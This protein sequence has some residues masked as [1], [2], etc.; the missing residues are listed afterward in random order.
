M[1]TPLDITAVVL[2]NEALTG[3]RCSEERKQ[4]VSGCLSSYSYFEDIREQVTSIVVS[5]LKGHF[6]LDGNKRTAL[7]IYLDLCQNNGIQVISNQDRLGEVFI[8]IA[9]NQRG[10]SENTRLLFPD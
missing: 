10:I 8:D 9:A 7:A 4:R 6:F 5:L 2:I 3:N 1:S